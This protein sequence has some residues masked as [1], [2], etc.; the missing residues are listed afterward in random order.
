MRKQRP[1]EERLQP[2][3]VMRP[4]TKETRLRRSFITVVAVMCVLVAGALS[5]II[6][7]S[8]ETNE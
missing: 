2:M 8:D 4:R 3:P 5:V 7:D 6:L 1:N